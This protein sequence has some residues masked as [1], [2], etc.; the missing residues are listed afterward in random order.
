[1]KFVLGTRSRAELQGVH[2]DLV[3]VVFRAIELTT[4]DFTVFDGFRTAEDQAELFRA[5][6]SQRDGTRRKSQHQKQKSGHGEAVDL[7]PWINGRARWEWGAIYPI[8]LAVRTA[9]QEHGLRLRWGGA[10]DRVLNDIPNTAG[11]IAGEVQAYCARH[12]GPD[13]IDGP[14]YEIKHLW[15][16]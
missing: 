10:W 1:M 12:P 11:A 5:G 14:H 7:V 4:Q 16:A 3:A 8:A 13:F 2:P 6:A 9:A 15:R